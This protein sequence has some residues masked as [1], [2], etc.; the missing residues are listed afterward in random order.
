MILPPHVEEDRNREKTALALPAWGCRLFEYGPMTV[1]RLGMKGELVRCSV[2]RGV[3]AAEN[4]QSRCRG[5]GTAMGAIAY[6][7]GTSK[8]TTQI[9]A[10]GLC[11]P[12]KCIGEF[13]ASR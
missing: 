9:S 2:S 13:P 3:L 5:N 6:S 8:E 12:T 1:T 7:S 10:F 4:E 11:A